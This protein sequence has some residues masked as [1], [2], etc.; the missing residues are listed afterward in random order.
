MAITA[1]IT[2]TSAAGDLVTDALSLSTSANL[3]KAGSSTAIANTSGLARRTTSYASSGV[4]DTVVLYRGDDYTNDGANKIYLKNTS[5]TAAEYF[6]VYMTGDRATDV[7]TN[8]DPG[9]TELGRLYAGDWAFFPWNASGGT[10]EQFTVTIAN[11]WASGDTFAFDGVT[12][13]AADSTVNNIAAQIDA[14]QYPNWVT[15][16]SGA[17]VTFVARYSNAGIEIDTSEA[18]STTA[19][20]G[21]GAVATT[22]EGTKSV[23]DI[24]IKPSVHTD[25]TIESM[26]FYE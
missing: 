13:V 16:V 26:L 8:A 25:M 22:V 4:I 24:Y 19:G 20:S 6:T 5:S 14:A 7:H 12:V 11:T 18:V 21:S 3:T 10:K 23:S 9:L 17:V 15:S 1:A 2:L